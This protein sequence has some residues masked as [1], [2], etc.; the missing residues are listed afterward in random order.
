M[1]PIEETKVEAR[2]G[3]T[4]RRHRILMVLVISTALAGLALL[5]GAA[6]LV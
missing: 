5:L 4:T 6:F 3:E 2:Q 1:A